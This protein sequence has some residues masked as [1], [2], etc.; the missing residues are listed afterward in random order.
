MAQFVID[1]GVFAKI[2]GTQNNVNQILINCVLE[3][4]GQTTAMAGHTAKPDFPLL[5][6]F[7]CEQSPLFILHTINGI[8]GVIEVDIEIVC[9]QAPQTPFQRTHHIDDGGVCTSL[10]L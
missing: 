10:G 6:C 5:L 4:A 7:F 9:L 1:I 3:A 2:V 8:D